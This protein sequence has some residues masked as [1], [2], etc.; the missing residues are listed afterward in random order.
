MLAEREL[1][2]GLKERKEEK[3]GK[4]RIERQLATTSV[5]RG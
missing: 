1:R 4:I 5:K 2:E 3:E